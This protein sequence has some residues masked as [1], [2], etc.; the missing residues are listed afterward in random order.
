MARTS[1]YGTCI[2]CREHRRIVARD[3]CNSCYTLFR[4]SPEFQ[5]AQS[6]AR[7]RMSEVNPLARRGLCAT[8]GPV[9]AILSVDRGQPVWRC[10]A[11]RAKQ[12]RDARARRAA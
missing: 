6:A 11:A 5:P 3:R 2:R 12:K 4:C 10:G 9:T 1:K 8:C 7:H